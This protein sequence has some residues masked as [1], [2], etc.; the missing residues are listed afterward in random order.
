MD[1]ACCIKGPPGDRAPQSQ[2]SDTKARSYPLSLGFNQCLGAKEEPFAFS[3][4]YIEDLHSGELECLSTL[5][6]LVDALPKTEGLASRFALRGHV[7]RPGHQRLCHSMRAAL[8][9][10]LLVGWGIPSGIALS[11]L[12]PRTPGT[13]CGLARG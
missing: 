10:L 1:Q 8:W 13:A 11:P 12:L 9:W 3:I 7:A 6:Q 2:Q 4:V 5:E